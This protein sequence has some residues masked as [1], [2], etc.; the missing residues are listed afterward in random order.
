MPAAALDFTISASGNCGGTPTN[1][2]TPGNRNGD[3]DTT[4]PGL[5]VDEGDQLTFAVQANNVPSGSSGT[6]GVNTNISG[7]AWNTSDL[8]LQSGSAITT[9]PQTVTPI[10]A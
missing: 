3:R 10:V 1:C 5:Q 8:T 6:W 2:G 4:W 9:P 7:S